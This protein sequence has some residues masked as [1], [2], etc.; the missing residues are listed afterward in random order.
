MIRFHDVSKIHSG[1]GQ[2]KLIL[3]GSNALFE[4]GWNYALMGPNGS[5][6]SS[7]M[8]LISGA[9]RPNSGHIERDEMVSWPLGFHGGFNGTMTGRENVIFVARIYGQDPD[10]VLHET[11][12]FAEIGKAMGA[13]LSTYSTG[14]RQRLAFGMSLSMRF[15]TILVDEIIA[16]GDT[17]FRK[18]C[19][20]ALDAR[21]EDSRAIVISH[22]LATIRKYCKRGMLLLDGTLYEYDDI[23][24]LIRDYREFCA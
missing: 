6:K 18:R 9:D 5:G 1:K 19:M 14:M 7:V 20:E 11:A 24:G 17:R 3:D 2:H 22:T 10:R 15:D 23:E 12:E 21:L 4:T 13:P 16:V 8:R